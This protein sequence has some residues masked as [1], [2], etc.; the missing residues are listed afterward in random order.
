MCV[1]CVAVC[2]FQYFHVSCSPQLCRPLMMTYLTCIY[3]VSILFCHCRL[4][5]FLSLLQPPA[6]PNAG[7]DIFNLHLLFVYSVLPPLAFNVSMSLAAPS[8]PNASDGGFNFMLFTFM[9]MALAL[10]LFLF[11]PNSLR[12]IRGDQKPGRDRV[13]TY[14]YIV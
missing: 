8:L 9:W 10:V 6:L 4:S 5:V 11:R 3:C 12:S 7:D 13:R 2:G 1:F 14:L